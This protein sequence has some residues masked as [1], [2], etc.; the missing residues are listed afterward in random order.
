MV[1]NSSVP[2]AADGLRQL[3]DKVDALVQAYLTAMEKIRLREGIRI[4]FEVTRTGNGFTTVHSRYMCM[5]N[6]AVGRGIVFHV[7]K[8]AQAA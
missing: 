8:R 1:P 7:G 6:S 2:S 4:A 3:G 5:A